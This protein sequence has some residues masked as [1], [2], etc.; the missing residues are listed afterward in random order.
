MADEVATDSLPMAQSFGYIAFLFG[1]MNYCI[2]VTLYDVGKIGTS[3][4]LYRGI[5]WALGR[6]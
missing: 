6:K 1:W 4:G 5:A 2:Q 3:M